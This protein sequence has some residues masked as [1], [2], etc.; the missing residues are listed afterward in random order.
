MAAWNPNRKFTRRGFITAGAV[1]A[2]GGAGAYG[3]TTLGGSGG[4]TSPAGPKILR[5][6]HANGTSGQSLDPQAANRFSLCAAFY[7]YLGALDENYT[8]Q[9]S[10]LATDWSVDNTGQ[11]WTFR[12]RDGVKFHDGQA[13]TSKDVSYTLKRALDPKRQSPAAGTIASIIDPAAIRT[14][15]PTTVIMELK[16]PHFELPTLLLNYR[17]GILPDGSGDTIGNTG[18]GT[19]PYRLSSFQPEVLTELQANRDYHAGPPQLDQLSIL[20][21]KDSQAR[22]NALMAGQVDMISPTLSLDFAAARTVSGNSSCKVLNLPSGYWDVLVMKV[23]KKPFDDPRVRLAFKLVVDCNDMVKRVLN[24]SG[25]AANHNPVWNRMPHHRDLRWQR[26]VAHAKSLLAAAGYPD[27]LQVQLDTA[28]V[29]GTLVPA[30][31]V[32][33]EAAREAGIEVVIKQHPAETY[34]SDAYKKGNFVVNYWGTRL[35]DQSL[36]E[37]FRSDSPGNES[38]WRNARMDSLLNEARAASDEGRRAELYGECQEL[39]QQESG[40]IIPYFY[41]AVR[42]VRS[43]VTNFPG[44]GGPGIP[45]PTTWPTWNTLGIK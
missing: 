8:A 38:G 17:L 37:F 9:P 26:D 29:T 20:E 34:Y 30:C 6:A 24:G 45:E 5:M 13:F 14:P 12:L 1:V 22:T 16:Q 35:P 19:G 21:I 23:D 2:A 11:R 7:G 32:F 18:I 15:D 3:L 10:D 41:N 28:P 4:T 40:H 31:V 43:N 27:G 39:V 42:A 33:A 44:Q 25:E 36:N